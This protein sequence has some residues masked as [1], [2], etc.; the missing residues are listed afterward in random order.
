MTVTKLT[1]H[2]YMDLTPEFRGQDIEDI[3]FLYS[4][5]IKPEDK[6]RFA[7][8]IALVFTNYCF[9][10]GLD[11]NSLILSA[12]EELDSLFPPETI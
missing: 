2:N 1:N 3:I 5:E 11:A 4:E 12:K 8:A 6:E 10:V 7:E 9:S